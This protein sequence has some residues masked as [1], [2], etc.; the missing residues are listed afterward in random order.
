MIENPNKLLIIWI[1]SFEKEFKMKI[2][3]NGI[4]FD[5][6]NASNN[7]E[8]MAT[9]PALAMLSSDQIFCSFRSVIK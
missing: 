6:A 9:F 2:L 7:K 5:A 4:I 8:K 1:E 3:D